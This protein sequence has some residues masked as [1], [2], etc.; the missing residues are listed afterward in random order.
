MGPHHDINDSQKSS[1]AILIHYNRKSGAHNVVFI[2]MLYSV[3]NSITYENY[4]T[5]ITLPTLYI[6]HVSKKFENLLSN[7]S[8]KSVNKLAKY[9]YFAMKKRTVN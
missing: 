4:P 7:L 9:I 2:V 8:K 6:K 1:T 3:N 5:N